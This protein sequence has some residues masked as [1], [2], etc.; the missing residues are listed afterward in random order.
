[1]F[2]A[3]KEKKINKRDCNKIQTIEDSKTSSIIGTISHLPAELIWFILRK[4]IHNNNELPKDVSILEN[5]EFWPSWKFENKRVE[6]DVFIRFKEFDLILE[7]KRNDFNKQYQGQWEKE[8]KAYKEKYR[9][10]V[11]DYYLIAISG[12]TEDY[13]KNVF[14]CSWSSLLD[15]VIEQLEK[16]KKE[17]PYSHIVRILND[18]ILAFNFHGEHYYK[19]FD[20]IDFD[21]KTNHIKEYY[22]IFKQLKK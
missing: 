1:M 11:K 8:I 2:Q 20:S 6:P 21:S 13:N 19:Y 16:H 7:L 14:Q 3:Y 17:N 10:D 5:I 4:S 9:N 15:V 12:K 18:I 22:N